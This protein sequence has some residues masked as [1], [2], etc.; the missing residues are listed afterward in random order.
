MIKTCDHGS[1]CSLCNKAA[2]V[3]CA[4]ILHLTTENERLRGALLGLADALDD[5][6]GSFGGRKVQAALTNALEVAR[7]VLKGKT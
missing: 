5:Y 6:A 2:E 4:Y 7:A 3:T 1:K